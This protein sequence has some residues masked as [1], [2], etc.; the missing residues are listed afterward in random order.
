MSLTSFAKSSAVAL[1]ALIGLASVAQADTYKWIT[2]KP[3][4]AGDAQAITTQ[5]LVDE[6]AKRTEGK[7]SITVFWGGSVAK[8][9]EI[10]EALAAG[11]GDFGD[12]ITPYF[13]DL[14]PLNNA[15]GF[16]IPQPMNARAVGEFMEEM[17]ATYPQFGEEL[18]AQNLHAMGFRPLEDYGLLCTKPVKSVADMKGLRI[19]S[20]G[21]AYPKLIEA[22]GASPVSI[23]TSEAYEALQRSI[24]DCTPIGP[25]LARGWKY[26]EVAKYYIEIPLGASFGHL[27]AMNLDTYN[28]MDD[29]TK[30]VV[31][32]LGKDYLVEYARVL[33]EDAAR[34][35]EL[36]KGDLGVE[37][38]PFPEEELLS[39]IDDA[40]V[41]GV[42]QEW[43]DKANAAG[44]P[45]EEIV[46]AFDFK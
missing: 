9:R 15:V 16:F 35:R 11:V 7:H 14:M 38:I 25:A 39:V 10:P 36:W 1:T 13:P 17:H 3:Q 26:D 18:A 44:V 34:V 33:D 32:Q 29:E 23:A 37:V 46:K 24:I 27:L 8:T 6:F 43:I 19:R 31:D 45:A 4:G 42:R 30:A 20:Y 5:W 28:G 2:F 40:G 21:F 41:Q 12:V 22:L